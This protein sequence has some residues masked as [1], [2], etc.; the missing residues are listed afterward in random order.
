MLIA[1]FW[2]QVAL[3][4]FNALLLRAWIRR[5][6]WGQAAISGGALLL[7]AAMAGVTWWLA[8]RCVLPHPAVIPYEA[9]MSLCPGQAT[10]ITLPVPL[11]PAERAL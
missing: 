1:L 7:S 5:R 2:F 8:G 3:V 4:A 6:R 9:G 10:L 11:P